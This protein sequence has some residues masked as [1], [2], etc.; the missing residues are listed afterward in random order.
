MLIL[1]VTF[2]DGNIVNV[3]GLKYI[4][5]YVAFKLKNKFP[6]LGTITSKKDSDIML[7]ESPWIKHVSKGGLCKPSHQFLDCQNM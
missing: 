3:E 7:C 4:A 6:G 2:Q 1:F 5:G